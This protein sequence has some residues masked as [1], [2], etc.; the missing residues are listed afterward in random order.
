[1]GSNNVKRVRI[2]VEG[3]VQGVFFRQKTK[4][5][6]ASLN[7]VG[8][9]KNSDD[10]KVLIEAQGIKECLDALISWVKIGPSRAVVKEIKVEWLTPRD[11]LSNFEII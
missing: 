2:I 1:M 11:D 9:V 3:K 5:E 6:A 10:G 8:W 4:E 7:L